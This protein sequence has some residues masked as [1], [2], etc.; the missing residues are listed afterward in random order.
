MIVPSKHEDLR[1]NFIFVG[2]EVIL[3]LK[4][5]GSENVENLFQLMKQKIGFNLDQYGNILTILWLG[6]IITISEHRIY[7]K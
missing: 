7:L 3:Y 4:K 6:G 1:K 5:H 2:A